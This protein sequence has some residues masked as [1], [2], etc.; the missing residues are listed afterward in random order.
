MF[1]VSPFAGGSLLSPQGM[2]KQ[3]VNLLQAVHPSE[4]PGGHDKRNYTASSLGLFKAVLQASKRKA[5]NVSESS[6]EAL[7]WY[8]LQRRYKIL[9]GASNPVT[10]QKGP[11]QKPDSVEQ[12]NRM[13]HGPPCR[14]MEA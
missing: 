6:S 7:A 5:A 8:E 1:W 9:E 14:S 2:R 4:E 13:Y 11:Q 10:K 12:S 3:L